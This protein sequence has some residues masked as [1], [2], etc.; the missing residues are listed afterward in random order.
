M[1]LNRFEQVL[2]EHQVMTET[3]T[4]L[5][6]ILNVRSKKN[7]LN[8]LVHHAQQAD[9]AFRFFPEVKAWFRA[10]ALEF[11]ETKGRVNEALAEMENFDAGLKKPQSG[12]E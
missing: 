10:I 2:R 7:L 9:A 1:A 5:C 11:P 4:M 6:D 3:I 8:T 12:T